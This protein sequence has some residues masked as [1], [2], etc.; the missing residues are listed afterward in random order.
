MGVEWVKICLLCL[1]KAG[2]WVGACYRYSVDNS[3]GCSEVAWKKDCPVPS[4]SARR[5]AQWDHLEALT[6]SHLELDNLNSVRD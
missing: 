4:W 1:L 2:L 3:P 5:S 6:H